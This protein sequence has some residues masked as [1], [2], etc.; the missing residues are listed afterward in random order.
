MKSYTK[1]LFVSIILLCSCRGKLS[2]E[3][4]FFENYDLSTGEYKLLVF[5]E[6]GLWIDDYQDFYIDDIETLKKMQ[7]QWIFK[8]K[9]DISACGYGYS[10]MLV[11]SDKV[12]KEAAVNIER[13]CEY[14]SG[15]IYFPKKYLSD[16]KTY[17]KRM[18]ENEKNSFLEKYKKKQ[19][20]FCSIKYVPSF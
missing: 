19:S 5:G 1:I 14:M 17:F 16:H 6:E 18:S 15:W 13:D 12:L 3:I 20:Y 10:I 8:Y 2:E 7:K 4:V 9:S 11:D